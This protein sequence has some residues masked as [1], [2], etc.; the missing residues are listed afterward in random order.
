MGTPNHY[1]FYLN[2][3]PIANLDKLYLKGSDPPFNDQ[4]Q[5]NTYD[6][7]WKARDLAQ[8]MKNVKCAVLVVGGWYDAE[9]LSSPHRTFNA[10]NQYNPETPTTLIEGPLF[11]GGWTRSDGLSLYLRSFRARLAVTNKAMP[12]A[13]AILP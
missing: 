4:L 7:Y 8:H 9:D 12:A 11:H 6:D 10:V 13:T 3:G 1:E 2:V 5:H